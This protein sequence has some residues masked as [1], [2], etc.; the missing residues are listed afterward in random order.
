M[1]INYFILQNDFLNYQPVDET[2]LKNFLESSDAAQYK[3]KISCPFHMMG[4]DTN[5]DYMMKYEYAKTLFAQLQAILKSSYTEEELDILAIYFVFYSSSWM[6]LDSNMDLLKQYCEK[7]FQY[8][9][10]NE[11][12]KWI[13]E[14]LKYVLLQI[15]SQDLENYRNG[16]IGTLIAEIRQFVATHKDHLIIE[17]IEE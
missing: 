7:A 17:T 13:Q 12:I 4:Q 2:A 3:Y 9:S 14:D 6:R 15:Y 5:T 11:L 8:T 1:N 10:S 16:K